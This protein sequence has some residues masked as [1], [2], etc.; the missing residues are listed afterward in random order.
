MKRS[1]RQTARRH[2][3]KALAYLSLGPALYLAPT[4]VQAAEFPSQP[5]TLIVGFSP[6]GSND[7]TARAIAEPLSKK[8]GVPVVVENKV[9]A[10][11]MIA[12]NDVA[13]SKADGHTL[14]VTS[15]SPL[16]ITPHTQGKT[17]YDSLKDFQP[18]SLIGITPETMAINPR[19]AAT[20]LKELVDAA[21]KGQISI[22]SSGTGGLP[23]L[24]IELFRSAAGGQVIHVPYKG[25]SPAVADTLAGHVDAIVVD[26]PAVYKQIQAGSLKGIAM[27]ND[28]RS[29]FLPDLPTSGEQ[30][31]P[32]FVGVNWIGLI[33]PK[34][35]PASTT[36]KLHEAVLEAVQDPKVKATLAS[37]AVEVATNKAPKEFGQF[38][39][40][41]YEKWGKIVKDAGI[42]T[43]Q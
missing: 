9:G 26:L 21:R 20:N 16:V 14:M 13:R 8:L 30:G 18:V 23:H 3:V 5:I 15:A 32:S 31:M 12:T 36:Q 40:A 2:A 38:I 6:G 28:K 41:E 17:P 42:N 33:G 22:A 10:S 11:G 19:V 1:K 39:N 4:L 37:A 25:A 43:A 29:E 34:G 7:I 24:T 27:A 35:M